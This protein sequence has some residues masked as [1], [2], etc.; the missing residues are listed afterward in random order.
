M[1]TEIS[2]KQ[3]LIKYLSDLLKIHP[4]EIDTSATF[5]EYGLESGLSMGLLAE[6]ER[7]MG[8][9]LPLKILEQ[10]PSIDNLAAYVRT[11]P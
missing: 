6:F 7:W 8:S 3:W 2:A 5:D 11:L 10:A 1:V 9:E 4:G